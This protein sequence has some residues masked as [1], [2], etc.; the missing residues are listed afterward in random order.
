MPLAK[1]VT[2]PDLR[3]SNLSSA[4]SVALA[5]AGA[6]MRC[7]VPSLPGDF[8]RQRAKRGARRHARPVYCG[9][10]SPS[11]QLVFLLAASR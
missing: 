10:G 3:T 2:V 5:G 8:D 11:G 9:P 4:T 7:T 6:S 1:T